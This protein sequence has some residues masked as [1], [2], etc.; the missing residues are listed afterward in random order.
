[1]IDRLCQR[2][3]CLPSAMMAEDADRILHSMILLQESG[4][5]SGE[6]NGE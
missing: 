1:M 2:Y 6:P 5:E 3:H 4:E